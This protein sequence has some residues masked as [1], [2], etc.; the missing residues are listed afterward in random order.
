LVASP[1]S[2]CV[3]DLRHNFV[4]HNRAGH[5]GPIGTDLKPLWATA[6]YLADNQGILWQA[7][8]PGE[9]TVLL[10]WEFSEHESPFYPGDG[11]N[12]GLFRAA[13]ADHQD[14]TCAAALH[15]G[16]MSIIYETE[17]SGGNGR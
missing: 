10:R 6:P 1:A 8:A 16:G 17:R 2:G 9:R 12:F 4:F 15:V 13:S 5:V 11:I 3:F 7:P 14:D